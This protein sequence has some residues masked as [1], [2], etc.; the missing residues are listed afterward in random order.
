MRIYILNGPNLNLLGTREPEIYGT[1]TLED[2]EEMCRKR[3]AELQ[4][5]IDFRQTDE[6]TELITWLREAS[7]GSQGVVINPAAF[8]HYSLAVA[9]AVAACSV[10]VVEVHLSNIYAREAWRSRSVVSPVARGVIAGLGA[11]GYVAAVEALVSI[12]SEEV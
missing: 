7:E 11:E 2:I 8:T 5:E 6:E 12:A 1:R 3:A 9:E 10:P 4:V